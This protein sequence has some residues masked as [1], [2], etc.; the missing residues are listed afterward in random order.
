MRLQAAPPELA[1]L[2]RHWRQW[3]AL[4]ALHVRPRQGASAVDLQEY[5]ALHRELLAACRALAAGLG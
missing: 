1:A 4:V 3:T 5:Q 2:R